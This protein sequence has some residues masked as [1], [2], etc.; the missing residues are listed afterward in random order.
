MAKGPTRVATRDTWTVNG[1]GLDPHDA[2]VAMVQ[3]TQESGM[4]IVRT[5][6]EDARRFPIGS[7]VRLELSVAKLDPSTGLLPDE[8]PVAPI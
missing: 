5:A 6:T 2:T 3:L 1:M 4:V 7:T 8:P